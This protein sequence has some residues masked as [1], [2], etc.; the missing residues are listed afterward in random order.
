MIMMGV[1]VN[2]NAAAGKKKIYIYGIYTCFLVI[3][4]TIFTIFYN[5]TCTILSCAKVLSVNK[6]EIVVGEG[7]KGGR[8]LNKV[9]F[10]NL[11]ST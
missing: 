2:E 6:T 11:L 10:F 5:T 9:T 3:V 7:R 8:K 4:Q 1:V